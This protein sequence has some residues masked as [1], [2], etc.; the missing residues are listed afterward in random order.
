MG[1]DLQATLAAFWEARQRREYFPTEWHNRLEL[2]Q[3]Y[4]L[5]LGLIDRQCAAGARQVGWKVGL[6]SPPMQRQFG[7]SEPIFGCLLAEGRK[8]SGH[9][10]G[11]SELIEPG[12]E[13]E[14]CLRL[15]A[16]LAG[17][18][19]QDQ[20]RA[21][22][23]VCHPGIEIIETR[24]DFR[25]QLNLAIADNSQQKAFVLGEPVPLAP[26]L[27]LAQVEVVVSINGTEVGTG[28]G[29]GVLGNPL[30]SVVW[31]A[32][33]L[34]AFGRELRAG[35]YIMTGSFT[36]QFALKPGDTVRA[37]F[38]GIGAVEARIAAS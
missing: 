37:E 3:A 35:D 36:R 11:A 20:V 28:R 18:P 17:E 12:A 30:N 34:D 15:R 25:K 6:T 7:H 27:N 8:S 22:V 32:R 23:E 5:Q 14:L 4:Q 2:T 31:L 10:F 24:G 9:V 26:G 33:K 21:A 29:E 16:P 13:I 1:F 19:D 38:F